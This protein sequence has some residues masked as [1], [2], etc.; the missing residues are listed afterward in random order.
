MTPG[1]F[2]EQTNHAVMADFGR[3]FRLLTENGSNTDEIAS[4]PEF[5]NISGNTEFLNLPLNSDNF[6]SFI[7]DDGAM[8]AI[9]TGN[10][11]IR[12]SNLKNELS[13]ITPDSL[14]TKTQ[15]WWIIDA[16][17]GFGE[18]SFRFEMANGQHG[19]VEG[20]DGNVRVYREMSPGV[21]QEQ[22]NHAVMAE[23]GRNFRLLTQAGHNHNNEVTAGTPASRPFPAPYPAWL[24]LN[25]DGVGFVNGNYELFPFITHKTLTEAAN[26]FCLNLTPVDRGNPINRLNDMFFVYEN[27]DMTAA[28]FN[29]TWIKISGLK[30]ELSGITPG[31][32]STKTQLWW[33]ID[34]ARGHGEFSFDF[35][36][37][38]NTTGKFI[39]N[40]GDVKILRC[41]GDDTYTDISNSS[42]LSKF[43]QNFKLLTQSGHNHNNE[44]TAG[45]PE[46]RPFPSPYPEW[47]GLTNNGVGFINGNYE[48]FP[49]ISEE[50]LNNAANPFCL[51]LTPIDRGNPI[52]RLND[53]FFVYDGGV[54]AA[55]YFD[56]TWMIISNLIPSIS[57]NLTIVPDGG[58]N[59]NDDDDDNDDNNGDNNSNNNNNAVIFNGRVIDMGPGSPRPA[60]NSFSGSGGSA[61]NS[62]NP[63]PGERR[64]ETIIFR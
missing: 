62:G 25:N 18:F 36:L 37:E 3:Y 55:A 47:L 7:F 19:I 49:L 28:Y 45:T 42:D 54:M 22:T 12:V 51:N 4:L 33:I 15:L 26:P 24:G 60:G 17:R 2:Q 14:S 63:A 57:N 38:D 46:S 50:T 1:V 30:P 23:F 8:S 64:F 53:M 9:R 59:N 56:G 32:L 48:L 13:G 44:V 52:N 34:A 11:F 58:N 41:N 35:E 43:S 10:T 29:N 20:K 6:M 31:S 16:A 27:G 5:L 21:F 61:G 39:G 40:N